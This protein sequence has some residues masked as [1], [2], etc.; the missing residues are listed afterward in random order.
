MVVITTTLYGYEISYGEGYWAGSLYI[1]RACIGLVTASRI[2][3]SFP[4]LL[5]NLLL[6]LL[7]LLVSVV[8]VILAS[9]NIVYTP[10]D[11]TYFYHG[12][13]TILL[14]LYYTL[15]SSAVL[16]G[17]VSLLSCVAAITSYRGKLE[18]LLSSPITTN[19]IIQ[20]IFTRKQSSWSE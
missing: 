5:L 20:C 15:L 8:V 6:D 16:A 2:S 11:I 4:S 19:N 13:L 12:Q 7:D 9:L 18:L 17:L 1:V 14:S 3:S 10:Y